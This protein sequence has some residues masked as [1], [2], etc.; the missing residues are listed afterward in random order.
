MLIPR[1]RR[2]NERARVRCFRYVRWGLPHPQPTHT[3][4]TYAVHVVQSVYTIYVIVAVRVH[5]ASNQLLVVAVCSEFGNSYA[6]NA[7][8]YERFHRRCRHRS[9]LAVA[10]PLALCVRCAHFDRTAGDQAFYARCIYFP[11]AK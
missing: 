9:A 5:D 6:F 11:A 4:N 10:G 3:T 8:P 7:L 2:A 1:V